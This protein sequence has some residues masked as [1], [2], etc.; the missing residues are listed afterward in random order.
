M[1]D[2]T[3]HQS[4][5][6]RKCSFSSLI[7]FLRLIPHLFKYPLADSVS[8]CLSCVCVCVCVFLCSLMNWYKQ[9]SFTSVDWSQFIKFSYSGKLCAIQ[10]EFL[11]TCNS[12]L[13]IIDVLCMSCSF[14]TVKQNYHNLYV[15]YVYCM[16]SSCSLTL[17]NASHQRRWQYN[18]A[19]QRLAWTNT[20]FLPC[21][22]RP[23]CQ[24]SVILLLFFFS[25]RKCK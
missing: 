3:L 24:S 23:F 5:S 18:C 25:L 2:R 17:R 21:P 20:V 4:L 7:T 8:T 14:Q 1:F 22:W 19:L 13:D 16:H 6:D 9:L 11:E 12:L 15:L 10:M